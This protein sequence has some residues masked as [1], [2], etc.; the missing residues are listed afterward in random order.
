MYLDNL[1]FPLKYI[2]VFYMLSAL[3]S[4]LMKK[5]FLL[6][7]LIICPLGYHGFDKMKKLFVL[8]FIGGIVIDVIAQSADVFLFLSDEKNTKSFEI[9]V[10]LA[11]IAMK[12][13]FA[14]SCYKFWVRCPEDGAS[15]YSSFISIQDGPGIGPDEFSI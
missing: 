4:V 13:V 2:T 8:L 3:I 15:A 1:A 6:G 11:L 10:H 7:G 5:Y 9:V 14:Y 12:V